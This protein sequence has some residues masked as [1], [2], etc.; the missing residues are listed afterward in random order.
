AIPAGLPPA[1]AIAAIRE[2]GGLVGLPHPFDRFRGSLLAGSDRRADPEAGSELSR[3]VDWVEAWN[4]RALGRGANERAAELARRH[5]LPGV[6]ASD[7]HSTLEVGVT[8]T[9]LEGDPS[10]RDG[11]LAALPTARIIPGRPS[12][13]VRFITPVAKTIHSFTRRGSTVR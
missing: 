5:G 7:A 2:Q 12:Y 9:V 8:Y 1:E 3:L 11:L 6:A 10:T 13:L 4:A